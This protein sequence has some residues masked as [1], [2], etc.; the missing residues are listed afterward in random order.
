[1]EVSLDI[2][3]ITEAKRIRQVCLGA[4]PVTLEEFV[5]VARFGAKISFSQEYWS[6]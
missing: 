3:K 5:A 6:R 2:S 4:A 1:M